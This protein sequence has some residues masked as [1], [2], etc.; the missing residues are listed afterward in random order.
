MRICVVFAAALALLWC[1][2]ATACP[3]AGAFASKTPIPQQQAARNGAGIEKERAEI[4]PPPHVDHA[5]IRY[6]A[7]PWGKARGLPQNGGYVAAVDKRTG[8]ELWIL[9]VYQVPYDRDMEGDKLDVF[10]TNLTLDPARDTL[11]V[12]NER[13]E[14]YSV[15]LKTHRVVGPLS[16]EQ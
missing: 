13:G 12:E 6:Q 11:R 4:P 3:P 15:D 5:G 8:A 1:G 2:R 7:V 16:P 9:K 14:V 10:I